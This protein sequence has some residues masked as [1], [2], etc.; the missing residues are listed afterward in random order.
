[1]ARKQQDLNLEYGFFNIIKESYIFLI[2][3]L[4]VNVLE[5]IIQILS[6]K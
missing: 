5:T 6:L 2:M 3:T 4:I 1:M